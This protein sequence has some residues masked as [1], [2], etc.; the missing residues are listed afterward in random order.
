M[1]RDP[2]WQAVGP[3]NALEPRPD[4]ELYDGSPVHQDS[5]RRGYRNGYDDGLKAVPAAVSALSIDQVLWE[6]FRYFAHTDHANAATH[7][8]V[9]RYSPI[10]FRLAEHLT[11]IL[12]TQFLTAGNHALLSEVVSHLDSYAEDK[13]R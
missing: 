1:D 3:D 9:V 2:D 13:G 7:T 4:Q 6:C 12:E 8:A 5:Y 11:P 10:T